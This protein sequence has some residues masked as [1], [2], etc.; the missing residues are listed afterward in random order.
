MICLIQV[1]CRVMFK[2]FVYDPSERTMYRYRLIEQHSCHDNLCTLITFLLLGNRNVAQSS[3][4]ITLNNI[5]IAPTF[6]NEGLNPLEERATPNY[7]TKVQ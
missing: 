4:S 3:I 1:S 2:L 7:A 6:S 5:F